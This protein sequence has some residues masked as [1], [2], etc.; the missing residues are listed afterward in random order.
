MFFTSKQ[1]L[2]GRAEDEVQ[3]G[4]LHFLRYITVILA[5]TRANLL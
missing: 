3:L 2:P 5:L 1:Y 4:L